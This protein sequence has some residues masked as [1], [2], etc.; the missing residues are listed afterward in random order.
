MSSNSDPVGPSNVGAT[1]QLLDS[2]S[3]FYRARERGSGEEKGGRRWLHLLLL[4]S[5]RSPCGA[6]DGKTSSTPSRRIFSRIKIQVGAG[7]KVRFFRWSLPP[8]TV[9]AAEAAEVARGGFT[10]TSLGFPS[11]LAPSSIGVPSGRRSL[12]C[13]L[14]VTIKL[15][16]L[17]EN[18]KHRKHDGAEER[19]PLIL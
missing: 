7:E 19:I 3:Q 16:Q 5:D 14:A 17:F 18:I 6:K 8:M 15:V 1:A 10:S 13:L 11:R 4:P 12:L 9:K 2:A